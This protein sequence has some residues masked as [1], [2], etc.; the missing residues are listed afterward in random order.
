[1]N[2]NADEWIVYDLCGYLVHAL[3]E[4]VPNEMLSEHMLRAETPL[5]LDVP[6]RDLLELVPL[7]TY[8]VVLHSCD[9]MGWTCTRFLLKREFWSERMLAGFQ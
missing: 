6:D 1:M 2:T 3:P 7:P 9:L 4:K 5:F 8:C